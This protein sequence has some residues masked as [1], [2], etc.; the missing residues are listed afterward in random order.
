MDAQARNNE[1]SE[2]QAVAPIL[3]KIADD[4]TVI[5]VVRARAKGLLSYSEA[6]AR[7]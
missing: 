6:A 1:L 5:N 3:Q 7:R 2:L 4:A